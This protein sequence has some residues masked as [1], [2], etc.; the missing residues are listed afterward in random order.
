MTTSKDT[1]TSYPGF[2]RTPLRSTQ[3]Q[4]EHIFRE[5]LAM[6]SGRIAG[7]ANPIPKAQKRA[8]RLRKSLA[9][10]KIKPRSTAHKWT[11]R[12]GLDLY[13]ILCPS[14]INLNDLN[15]VIP[16][17][18]KRPAP[19]SSKRTTPLV[20]PSCCETQKPECPVAGPIESLEG[21]TSAWIQRTEIAAQ[22]YE[23]M[24]EATSGMG[25][26]SLKDSAQG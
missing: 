2:T 19:P 22:T 24:I 21:R 20:L 1:L 13:S 23:T 5:P 8:M 15:R 14:S 11:S 6:D 3:H 18:P 10:L 17:T 4:G 7:S 26:L 16:R 9:A 25:S 12:S